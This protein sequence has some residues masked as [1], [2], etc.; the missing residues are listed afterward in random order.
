MCVCDHL[1]VMELSTH[2]NVLS[3]SPKLPTHVL[4]ASIAS[5]SA[6]DEANTL[7]WLVASNQFEVGAKDR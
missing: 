7:V 5:N 4:A 3:N 2:V 6:G 1:F